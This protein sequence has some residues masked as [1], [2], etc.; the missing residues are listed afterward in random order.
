MARLGILPVCQ[1]FDSF[2]TFSTF[3][4][5]Q[6]ETLIKADKSIGFAPIVFHSNA[7]YIFGGWVDWK[8]SNTISR[9]DAS[10]MKWT[11]SGNLKTN[12]SGHGAIFN[13]DLVLVAGGVGHLKTE[14][15]SITSGSVSCIE[16]KPILKDYS[17]YPELYLVPHVFCKEVHLVIQK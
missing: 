8:N 7:F 4:Q 9:L 12:R 6:S 10:T 2:S 1:G 5:S 11:K 17:N 13:G 16:Q 14:S 3:N 15:C